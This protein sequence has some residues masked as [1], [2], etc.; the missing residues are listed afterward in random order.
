MRLFLYSLCKYEF[1]VS[2]F[3]GAMYFLFL[4]R[5]TNSESQFFF[6]WEMATFILSIR[7]IYMRL[8]E[9][10]IVYI[11]RFDVI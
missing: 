8:F 11:I 1:Y 9:E 10:Y 3:N 7:N 2:G 5:K 6:V 4:Q